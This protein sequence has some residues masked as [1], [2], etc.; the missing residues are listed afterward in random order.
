MINVEIAKVKTVNNSFSNRT[1]LCQDNPFWQ[2]AV[3]RN[4]DTLHGLHLIVVA[5]HRKIHE[6]HY[7]CFP[8]HVHDVPR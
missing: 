4:Q 7:Q 6:T 1:I 3:R 8:Q 2:H 5:V